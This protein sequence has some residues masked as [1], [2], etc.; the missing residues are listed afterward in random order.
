MNSI[1]RVKRD[2]A[3]Y[4]VNKTRLYNHSEAMDR[5]LTYYVTAEINA[6]LIDTEGQYVFYIGD[7]RYY[8]GYENHPLEP[9]ISY[10]AHFVVDI[11]RGVS[12]TICA[13]LY[14]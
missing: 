13:R 14:R 12:S 5:N 10:T 6:T 8:G 9:D 1:S 2:V 11:D 7:G 3:T 4:P